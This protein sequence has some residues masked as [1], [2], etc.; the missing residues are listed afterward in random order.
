MAIAVAETVVAAHGRA[1]ADSGGD[2]RAETGE[3]AP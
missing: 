1:D 3:A 2:G